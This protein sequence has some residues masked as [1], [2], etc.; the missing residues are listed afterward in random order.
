MVKK[1]HIIM[2]FWC[3]KLFAVSREA[4]ELDMANAKLLQKFRILGEVDVPYPPLGS[5][6]LAQFY[7]ERNRQAVRIWKEKEEQNA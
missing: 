2:R 6:T 1:T 4:Y 7:E 5:Q 3:G